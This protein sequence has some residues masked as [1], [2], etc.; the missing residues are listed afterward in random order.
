MTYTIHTAPVGPLD[1]KGTLELAARL[2]LTTTTERSGD[3]HRY[4][5]TRVQI[6]TVTIAPF[7]EPKWRD[8]GEGPSWQEQYTLLQPVQVPIGWTPGH[9]HDALQVKFPVVS[10]LR[11]GGAKW[12]GVSVA[13]R[14]DTEP[15]PSTHYH[16]TYEYAGFEELGTKGTLFGYPASVSFRVAFEEVPYDHDPSKTHWIIKADTFRH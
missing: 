8:L 9:G 1:H 5:Y 16:S 7:A 12:G 15:R 14:D 11:Q 2:G 13:A 4:Q 3:R 6:G 10:L